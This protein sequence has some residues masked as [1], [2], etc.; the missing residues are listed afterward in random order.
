M[1][2]KCRF[3]SCRLLSSAID[4]FDAVRCRYTLSYVMI[5][6]DQAINCDHDNSHAVTSKPRDAAC[7]PTL[8]VSMIVIILL[9]QRLN[10]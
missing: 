8:R 10:V 3:D 9:Q 7:F 4:M 6:Q 1:S 5:S 2:N